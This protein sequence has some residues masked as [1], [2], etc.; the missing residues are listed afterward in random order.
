MSWVEREDGLR[1]LCGNM[2]RS[3]SVIKWK[4]VSQNCGFWMF[5]RV[6]HFL[7]PVALFTSIY[8]KVFWVLIFEHRGGW[9]PHWVLQPILVSWAPKPTGKLGPLS[10]V[11]VHLWVIFVPTHHKLEIHSLS[12]W[13]ILSRLLSILKGF[14]TASL[15]NPR[16]TFFTVMLRKHC[17]TPKRLISFRVFL[18][19]CQEKDPYWLLNALFKTNWPFAPWTCSASAGSGMRWFEVWRVSLFDLQIIEIIFL[20]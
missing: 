17:N 6:E 12:A 7:S 8:F 14:Q 13:G 16:Y 1:G 19:R 20:W 2:V 9:P 11:S 3:Q 5:L 15:R 4:H 18:S 10:K